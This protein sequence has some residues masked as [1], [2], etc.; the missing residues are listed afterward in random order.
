MH[1]KFIPSTKASGGR[2]KSYR[3]KKVFEKVRT[4]TYT[5]LGNRKTRQIR[6]NAGKI[7]TILLADNVANVVGKDG[8]CKKAKIK[9]VVEN[10]ANTQLV[11][12]NVITKGA[13]VET[14]LGKARITSRPGQ[15]GTI[16]A[17]LL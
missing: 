4:P 2:K 8:K 5:V 11:R 13:V 1:T 16:N 17:V 15:E 6:V 9:T 7:K 12:R 10:P 3:K 14:E